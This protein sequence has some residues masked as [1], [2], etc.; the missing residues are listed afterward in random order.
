M[1]IIFEVILVLFHPEDQAMGPQ[2]QEMS[3][4]EQEGMRSADTQ[5]IAFV[6]GGGQAS[7]K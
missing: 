4:R 3:L 7:N 1:S 6:G 2:W 5:A